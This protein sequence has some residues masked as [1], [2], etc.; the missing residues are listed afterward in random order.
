MRHNMS[1]PY[2]YILLFCGDVAFY[3]TPLIT[4]II[5][6]IYNNCSTQAVRLCGEEAHAVEHVLV[7]ERVGAEKARVRASGPKGRAFTPLARRRAG[8]VC[9]CFPAGQMGRPPFFTGPFPLPR[10]P[11]PLKMRKRAAEAGGQSCQSPAPKRCQ[12]SSSSRAR[13][14]SARSGSTTFHH[15]PSVRH[16]LRPWF[17]RGV[18][19]SA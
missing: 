8:P 1:N 11:P 14:R 5:I 16:P 19:P 15:G 13:S 2:C 3:Y 9:L 6:I 12:S 10:P 18:G 7:V 4:I 17:D